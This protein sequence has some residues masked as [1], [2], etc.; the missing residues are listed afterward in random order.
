MFLYHETQ[1]NKIY[2]NLNLNL[3]MSEH[4]DLKNFLAFKFLKNCES[5]FEAS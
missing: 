4:I 3:T 5:H 2:L 1:L